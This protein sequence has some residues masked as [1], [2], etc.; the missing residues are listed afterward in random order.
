MSTAAHTDVARFLIIILWL[1]DQVYNMNDQIS[2]LLL[3]S[4][5]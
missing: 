3:V 5:E 2:D 1:K 4:E